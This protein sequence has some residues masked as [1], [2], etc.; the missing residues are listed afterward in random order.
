MFI[1][2]QTLTRHNQKRSKNNV[3]RTELRKVPFSVVAVLSEH[4]CRSP[5]YNWL[6]LM[7]FS[8]KLVPSIKRSHHL[9]SQI[10]I[11]FLKQYLVIIEEKIL[12]DAS[13]RSSKSTIYYFP[14]KITCY[15]STLV[16]FSS[17]KYRNS[18]F[19]YF[20]LSTRLLEIQHSL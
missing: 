19:L 8:V 10:F 1:T 20:H 9:H 6:V 15:P 12:N 17:R 14:Q 4:V 5:I 3:N 16:T 18:L 11:A 2:Y 7:P 13:L